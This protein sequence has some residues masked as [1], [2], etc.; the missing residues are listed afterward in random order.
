[1]RCMCHSDINFE[2]GGDSFTG[3]NNNDDEGGGGNTDAHS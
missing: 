1:M 2:C 3:N